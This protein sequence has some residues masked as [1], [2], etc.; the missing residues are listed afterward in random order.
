[1]EN[2]AEL[3]K[4]HFKVQALRVDFHACKENLWSS[5]ILR[6]TCSELSRFQV[7]KTPTKALSRTCRPVLGRQYSTIFSSG[8]EIREYLNFFDKFTLNAS[9]FSHFTSDKY[10]TYANFCV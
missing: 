5:F 1:M 2:S 3:E 7:A 6:S 10:C 9:R 4:K 8:K